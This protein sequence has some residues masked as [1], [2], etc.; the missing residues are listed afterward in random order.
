[1]MLCHHIIF[2]LR[3]WDQRFCILNCYF[4]CPGMNAPYLESLEQIGH[5]FPASLHRIKFHIFHNI[6]KCL[7]H[8]LMPFKYKNMCELCDNIQDKEKRGNIMVNN[9]S[10]YSRGSY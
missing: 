7:I 3:L 5:L 2:T 10:C 1:M 8:V 6:S 9:F 4:Y